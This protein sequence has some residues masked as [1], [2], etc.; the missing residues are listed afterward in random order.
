MTGYLRALAVLCALVG[1]GAIAVGL[2][3]A[4]LIEVKW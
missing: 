4:H 3:I 2:F 1:L